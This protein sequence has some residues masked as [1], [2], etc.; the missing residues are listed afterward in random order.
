V[1][2]SSESSAG[3]AGSDFDVSNASDDEGSGS[4]FEEES[5]GR[6]LLL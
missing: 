1:Q 6:A 2:M 3:D 5:E 4:D